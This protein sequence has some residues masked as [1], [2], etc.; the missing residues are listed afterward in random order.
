LY[1]SEMGKGISP[2]W[3]DF[4]VEI[5]KLKSPFLDNS[6]VVLE[7]FHQSKFSREPTFIGM[8]AI[9]VDQL[10]E[11]QSLSKFKILNKAKRQKQR[12]Y[13][14][15]GE[16]HPVLV[17][18]ILE[19]SF[20]DYLKGKA[21][22]KTMVALDFT[23]DNGEIDQPNSLHYQA[24]SAYCN[25]YEL[26]MAHLLDMLVHYNTERLISG[27]G[28]GAKISATSKT[29]HCFP[30]TGKEGDP[31]VQGFEGLK[32]AY[33]KAGSKITLS[34][35]RYLNAVISSAIN[36]AREA[37]RGN[38]LDYVLLLV[39]INGPNKDT[40]E[41]IRTLQ[42]IKQLPL[43]I[44]FIGVGVPST[45]N[46]EAMDLS[47]LHKHNE[48]GGVQYAKYVNFSDFDHNMP[49]F[50]REVLSDIPAAMT[51]Y[52]KEHG[53]SPTDKKLRSQLSLHRTRDNTAS[54]IQI[55]YPIY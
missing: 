36:Y 44:R 24:G 48:I 1:T 17:H 10:I 45:S 29:S 33:R 32:L 22:V 40:R 31:F 12:R 42:K 20:T 19:P 47:C 13:Q 5:Q 21:R 54:S 53:L 46:F 30:L 38:N 4:D 23:V 27:Y 43:M 15:S 28:F 3:K 50:R 16:I 49:A 11:S 52:F 6:R 37:S 51:R 26:A 35:P 2:R 55:D 9:D 8:Q 14:N 25:E 41:C 18:H 39:F 34:S 7:V